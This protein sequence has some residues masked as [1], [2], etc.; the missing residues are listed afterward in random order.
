MRDF[1]AGQPDF[2]LAP[3]GRRASIDYFVGGGAYG[4]SS[5][6]P[7]SRGNDS[8]LGYPFR[9]QQDCA[10]IRVLA[11]HTFGDVFRAD[12]EFHLSQARQ[13]GQRTGAFKERGALN[14]LLTLTSDERAHG[15]IAASA[16]NHAQGVSLSRGGTE[17]G[18]GS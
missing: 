5:D 14:K 11:V 16:G 1:W 10:D 2:P 13:P 18:H 4:G 15:V 12:A 17:F 3:T 8:T 9:P 6:L 7:L